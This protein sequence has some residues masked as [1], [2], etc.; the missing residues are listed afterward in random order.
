LLQGETYHAPS[1]TPRGFAEVALDYF[2]RLRLPLR[3]TETNIQGFC[4][5]RISWLK[6]MRR[7]YELLRRYLPSGYLKGFDW[8]PLFDCKGWHSLL[9]AEEWP[10]DPQG[11]FWCDEQGRRRESELSDWYRHLVQGGSSD[12][13]PAYR[14]QPQLE[15]ELSGFLPQMPWQWE[16]TT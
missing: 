5:D 9:Q 11:I 12:D 14:F 6:Y 1:R 15:Q 13:L 4:S 10:W 8:Y 2:D 7:Q 3:L 16:E